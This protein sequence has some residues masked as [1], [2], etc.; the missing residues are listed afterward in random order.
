M[1]ATPDLRRQTAA[2]RAELGRVR[3]ESRGIL[4]AAIVFSIFVNLLMLTGPIYMLQIYDRVLGSRSVPTLVALSALIAFLF[5]AMG[6]LD[7]ARSRILARIGARL[8]VRLDRRVFEAA[9]TRSAQSPGDPLALSAQRD[10]QSMQQFWSSPIAAAMIDMPWTPVFLAAIF[11]FHPM[12][13]WLAVGGGAV[14]IVL[15]LVNQR[16]SKARILHANSA[17]IVADHLADRL[18]T[19][20]ELLRAL[21]MTDAAFRRWSAARS[22]ALSSGMAS[23][24]LAGGFTATTR[25]LRMVDGRLTA[26]RSGSAR[27]ALVPIAT[28]DFLYEDG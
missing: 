9:L 6:L 27:S 5:L 10:L 12:L 26:Q 3:R 23:S 7:H 24:D 11:V 15:A 8:Q 2:G 21:G 1:T 25:T 17:G 20:A 16:V 22:E 4:I 28:A 13:G 14:L 19:E 18:K